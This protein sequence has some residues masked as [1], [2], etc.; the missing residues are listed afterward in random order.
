MYQYQ[1][2]E[3]EIVKV[4]APT[5]SHLLYY[6]QVRVNGMIVKDHVTYQSATEHAKRIR[7]ALD[8]AE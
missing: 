7:L 1:R 8:D 2:I 4:N 6:W 3:L 5:D